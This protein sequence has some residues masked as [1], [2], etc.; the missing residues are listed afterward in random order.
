LSLAVASPQP[1][2]LPS[3]AATPRSEGHDVASRSE[4]T[5]FELARELRD[6]VESAG[7]GGRVKRPHES[8]V[9]V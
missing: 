6:N 5:R 3:P 2:S 9:D 7:N 1:S 8:R 4:A